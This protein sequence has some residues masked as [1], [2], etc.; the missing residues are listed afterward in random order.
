MLKCC[1]LGCSALQV[2]LGHL[3]RWFAEMPLLKRWV[4]SWII[5]HLNFPLSHLWFKTQLHLPLGVLFSFRK[6]SNSIREEILL[7]ATAIKRDKRR[8][9]ER[10]TST[11]LLNG[12]QKL[13][14]KRDKNEDAEIQ[15]RI[16]IPR[17]LHTQSYRHCKSNKIVSASTI[18]LLCDDERKK[19]LRLPSLHFVTDSPSLSHVFI[20]LA[21]FA[22][23]LTAR[24]RIKY[25][26]LLPW[27]WI[28][29]TS[30]EFFF[31]F[32]RLPVF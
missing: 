24:L 10:N 32:N 23:H 6:V 15:H 2:W 31:G 3:P 29:T 16:L 26:P 18:I 30:R 4:S 13:G 1:K 9:P 22:Y 19:G 17:I 14:K 20:W 8:I 11:V 7:A 28:C 25:S 21:L 27:K 5:K 12:S